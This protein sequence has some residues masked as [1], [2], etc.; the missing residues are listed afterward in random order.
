MIW[1]NCGSLIINSKF[2]ICH[3]YATARIQSENSNIFQLSREAHPPQTRACAR[4]RTLGAE[5][6]PGNFLILP[7]PPD[8]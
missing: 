1:C 8:S 3:V 5:A 7:P 6:P 4:K 2:A